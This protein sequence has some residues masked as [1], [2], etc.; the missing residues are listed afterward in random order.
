MTQL[1][2]RQAG[3]AMA[4]TTVSTK[5]QVVIPAEVRRAAGI[6]PGDVL[7]VEVDAEDGTVVLRK[8]ESLAEMRARFTSWITPGTPALLD[9]SKFYETREPRR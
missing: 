9:A 3:R 8:Q 2:E 5:G 6:Q 4:T 1:D 7:R